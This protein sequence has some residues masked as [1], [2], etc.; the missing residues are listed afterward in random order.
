MEYGIFQN[1]KFD[2]NKAKIF[3][4]GGKNPDLKVLS[5]IIS[6]RLKCNF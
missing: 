5:K 3:Y 4:R 2:K 6:I 1:G